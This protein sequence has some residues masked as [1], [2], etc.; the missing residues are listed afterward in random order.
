MN[1]TI[2]GAIQN[3]AMN[4]PHSKGF[5]KGK[6]SKLKGCENDFVHLVNETLVQLNK[7]FATG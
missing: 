2:Y 4:D 7:Y 3:M 1:S 5:I 6:P